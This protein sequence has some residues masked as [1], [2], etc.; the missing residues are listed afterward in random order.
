MVK[1]HV[2]QQAYPLTPLKTGDRVRYIGLD[3]RIRADYGAEDLLVL[4]IN[5]FTGI[6]VCENKAGLRLVGVSSEDL[7]LL[8]S[9]TGTRYRNPL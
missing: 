4:L 3:S 7:K 8:H 6:A 9:P 2:F 5:P 1:S